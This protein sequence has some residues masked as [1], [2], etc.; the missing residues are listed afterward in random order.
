MKKIAFLT[1]DD[2]SGYAV[3]EHHLYDTMKLEWPEVPFDVIPWSQP[4]DWGQYTFA[5]IRTTWDYTKRYEEFLK[6]LDFIESTGC[7]VLN[8]LGI[9]KWNSHKSYLQDL[10]K[11]GVPIIESY[12]LNDIESNILDLNLKL[13]DH[14]KYVLKPAVGASAV[15]IDVLSKSEMLDKISKLKDLSLWFIQPFMD[16]ILQ[17]EISLFFFNSEFSHAAQKVP[18]QGDFRV[19]AEYGGVITAYIPNSEEFEF[20]KKVLNAIGQNLLYVRIDFLRTPEGP[21]VMELELIEPSFYFRTHKQSAK[22]FVNALKR[23]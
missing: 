18:K 22:N 8:P 10:E 2:L 20:A 9:V 21:R 16:E 6:T 1:C 19:Q 15:N 3:D 14:K 4:T 23:L 12:F 11:S 7:K 5:V 13:L 17:G